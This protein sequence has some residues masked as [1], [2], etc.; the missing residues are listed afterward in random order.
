[1]IG[2]YLMVGWFFR[3]YSWVLIAYV[4][5]SWLRPSGTLREIYQGLGT[6]CEPY[7]GIFRRFVPIAG[8]MDFSPLVALIVLNF[9]G[10]LLVQALRSAGL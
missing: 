8:G 3:I 9:G 2:L 4:L 7:L 6:I 10:S 1:M 5:M